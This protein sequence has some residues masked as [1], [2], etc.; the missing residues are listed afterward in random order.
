MQHFHYKDEI[1]I[2]NLTSVDDKIHAQ[3]RLHPSIPAMSIPTTR[4]APE[5]QPVLLSFHTRYQE[6]TDLKENLSRWG[7]IQKWKM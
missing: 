1:E 5:W 3:G 7:R 6:I 2:N 4:I